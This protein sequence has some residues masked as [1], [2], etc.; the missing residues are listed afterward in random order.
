MQSEVLFE[1]MDGLAR[2]IP[3]LQR[4]PYFISAVA[5]ERTLH[6]A[7][8]LPRAARPLANIDFPLQ[9]GWGQTISDP[10]IV[11]VMTAS[12]H[13]H[14]GSNVLEIG[15]GSG[16]QAAVLSR[17]GARVSTIEIVPQL[18]RR[19]AA[20]LRRLDFRNV[21]T[22]QGDGFVG[23]PGRAPFDAIV[24]TA[25]SDRIPPSLLDQL[26]PGGRLVM[27]IG[28]STVQEQLLVVEKSATGALTTCSL[29]DAMFVPFTG[30][31]L[32]P[33]DLHGLTDRSHPLCFG[34]EVT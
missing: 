20:T 10:W 31:G 2:R 29:G 5:A 14:A 22:R 11:A 30:K 4:D 34:A 13:V 23:W 8:F 32:R 6:R 28:P 27:P 3:L 17:L 7:D 26:A 9:I 18:A 24:V 1:H 25:G 19:A 33:T 16:Y 12:V 15:T 21:A